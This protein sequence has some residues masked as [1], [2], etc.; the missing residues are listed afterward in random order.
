M[1]GW[2][3]RMSELVKEEAE[4]LEQRLNK[5]GALEVSVSQIIW[6]F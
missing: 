2:K 6:M 1:L 5:S 3:D 4:L